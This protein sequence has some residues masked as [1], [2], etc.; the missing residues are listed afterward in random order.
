MLIISQTA[1]SNP[2][3]VSGPQVE[4]TFSG[5]DSA[6]FDFF[7][8]STSPTSSQI[9]SSRTTFSTSPIFPGNTNLFS[10]L[11]QKVTT[12]GSGSRL[13][14]STH[15]VYGLDG[16]SIVTNSYILGKSSYFDPTVTSI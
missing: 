13:F 8:D 9:L 10:Q 3:T 2:G 4:M 15:L 12:V 11:T 5:S 7:A 6:N 16:K 14:L 1:G